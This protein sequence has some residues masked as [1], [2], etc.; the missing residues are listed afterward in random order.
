[1]WEG[2]VSLEMSSEINSEQEQDGR[3]IYYTITVQNI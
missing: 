1:M 2:T 3:C